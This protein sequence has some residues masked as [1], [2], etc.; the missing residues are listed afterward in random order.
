[1]IV[2]E[3]ENMVTGDIGYVQADTEQ[4]MIG[5]LKAKGFTEA[6][7]LFLFGHNAKGEE[8]SAMSHMFAPV[9]RLK[10]LKEQGKK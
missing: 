4:Q 3:I 6:P 5:Q 1:M 10:H 2:Y 7:G 9:A 8:V